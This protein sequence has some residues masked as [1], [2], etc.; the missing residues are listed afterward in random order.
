MSSKKGI[1]IPGFFEYTVYPLEGF[2]DLTEIGRKSNFL[3]KE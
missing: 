3:L 2:W 1:D